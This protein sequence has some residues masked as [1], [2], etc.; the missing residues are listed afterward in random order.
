MSFGSIYMDF[1]DPITAEGH[2]SLMKSQGNNIDPWSNMA[3]RRKYNE[4]LAYRV[5]YEL[6]DNIRI[7]PTSI[8]ASLILMHR[9]G[10]N[11]KDLQKKALWL[12][13][14]LKKR[15]IF[16]QTQGLPTKNT[17]QIGLEHLKDY[18][19]NKRGSFQPNITPQV[20]YSNYI[21]LWYYRNPLNFA[22]FNEAIIISSIFSFGDEVA[23]ST[24]VEKS[25]IF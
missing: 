16:L 14:T 9:K 13:Q 5:V 24:G 25:E 23:W 1:C 8:V 3:D 11:E 20:D 22:F 15:N 19:E 12:G 7:M 21:M 4:D 10:I 17:I 2:L 18:L 6:Q